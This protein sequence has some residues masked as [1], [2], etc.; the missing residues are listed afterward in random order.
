MVIKIGI[1]G[2]N[3]LYEDDENIENKW[4]TVTCTLRNELIR[5]E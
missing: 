4:K 2:V 3:N 5:T 1:F